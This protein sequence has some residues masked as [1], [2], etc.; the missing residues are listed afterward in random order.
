MRFLKTVCTTLALGLLATSLPAQTTALK[1][2]RMLDV[3]TGKIISPALVVVEKNRIQSV[4]GN[5][6]AGAKV[7]DLGDVTLLPGF[8]DMHTHLSLQ[9]SANMQLKRVTESVA[10]NAIQA[11]LYARKT[12]LAGFTTVRNLG[13]GNFV[14]I[15]LA[16][17]SRKGLIASPR[18]IPSAHALSI[19]GG[20]GD[21]GGFAPGVVKQTG[22]E[23]GVADGVAE[24]VKAVRYQI[25]HGAKVIKIS[26]TAGVLSFEESVGAQQYTFEEIKAI[27]D[28]AARH[29][30]KVAAHAHGT[31]GI[32]AAVKAG[33]ASIE[34]GSMLNDEAIRLMK[35][36]GTY[37]IPT[38]YLVGVIDLDILPPIIRKKAEYVLPLAVESTKR[39]IRE[40]VKV[41]FGT[42]AGVFPHGDNAK[43]FA[44]L[45]ERG[46]TPLAAIQSATLHAADLLG[47]KDR[48]SIKK[49][50]LADIIAVPGNPLKNIK[51]V[52]K[53]SFVMKDGR[54]YKLNK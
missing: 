7:I 38:T 16:N 23:S 2:S 46:M 1:A 44:V 20:H 19:T 13:A 32:I 43:E 28:E 22:I 54:V 36:K 10:D 34:H 53:V 29:G 8:M 18:I 48:G 12:L 47:V 31:E 27:V 5:A 4:G 6:P 45:V 39:A 37:Y 11:T 26:A 17:A 42:D 40:G 41:A 49:G 50:L 21:A 15:S 9:I 14:D 24:V 33:V 35:E 30:V 52:E 25:K 3:E 51:T